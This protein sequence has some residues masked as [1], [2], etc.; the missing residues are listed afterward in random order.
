MR[1]AEIVYKLTA[2]LLESRF[3][4]GNGAP[5]LHLFGQL[6]RIVRQWLDGGHLRCAGGTWPAQLLYLQ[7]ADMA[8]EKIKKGIDTAFVGER[9]MT[10]VMDPHEAVGT[11][12]G[13]G[14]NTSK[15]SLWTSGARQWKSSESASMMISSSLGETHSSRPDLLRKCEECPAPLSH[16]ATSSKRQPLPGLW[17]QSNDNEQQFV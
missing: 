16:C 12:A 11:T 3:R 1:Q 6:K 13:V 17:N 5:Q 15:K 4:D 9:P 2:R 7:I 10:V 8:C 14:F